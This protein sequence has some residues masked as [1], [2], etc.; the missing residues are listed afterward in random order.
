MQFILILFTTE[1]A[2]LK[3]FS[4]RVF[5]TPFLFIRSTTYEEIVLFQ[6]ILL[7]RQRHSPREYP[8]PLTSP[9]VLAL[10]HVT[11]ANSLQSSNLGIHSKAKFFCD[12]IIFDLIQTSSFVSQ[13][14]V[15]SPIVVCKSMM[16]I[17]IHET[18]I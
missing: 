7:Q 3:L 6:I 16:R 4:S 9:K 15:F 2:A 12:S 13:Q 5:L 18:R 11:H 8:L 1:R 10:Y 17:T 14:F